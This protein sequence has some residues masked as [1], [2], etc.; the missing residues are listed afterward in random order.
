MR[1]SAE[2]IYAAGDCAE[3][4]DITS[5]K[6]Y[7]MALWPP[8]VEQG[9]VAALNMV[10]LETTYPGTLP[11]NVVEVFN[12]TFMSIG[13]LEG[14][15]IDIEKGGRISRFTVNKKGRVVGC[16]LIGDINQVGIISSF[17]K[18][19]GNVEDLEHIELIPSG[20]LLF[21]QRIHVL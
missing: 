19:G 18:K 6:S 7:V 10:S 9:K 3:T 20:R 15:K 14:E 17:I 21:S 13:S 16:Q 8:A 11:G 5:G 12:T 4:V 2:D 1:T